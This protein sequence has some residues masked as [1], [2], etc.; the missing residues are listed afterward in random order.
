MNVGVPRLKETAGTAPLELRCDRFDYQALN[1]RTDIF[2]AIVQRISKV[3][4]EHRHSGRLRCH[5]DLESWNG[6]DRRDA[7]GDTPWGS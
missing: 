6:S 3:T 2:P 5:S 7:N 1:E 4:G